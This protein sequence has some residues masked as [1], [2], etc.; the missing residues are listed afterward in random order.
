MPVPW[1]GGGKISVL[2][3]HKVISFG[4]AYVIPQCMQI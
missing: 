1:A 2:T 4:G 3:N